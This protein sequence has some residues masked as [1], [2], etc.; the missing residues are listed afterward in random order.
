MEAACSSQMLATQPIP[1]SCETANIGFVLAV[2]Y[3]KGL[4]SAIQM[5]VTVVE[6]CSG[7]VVHKTS[8]I[9]KLTFCIICHCTIT[10]GSDV[11]VE[12]IR[13]CRLVKNYADM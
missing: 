8:C 12:Y 13:G 11:L 2:N 4:N 9:K 7:N 5:F 3:H 1:T 6:H 10:Y